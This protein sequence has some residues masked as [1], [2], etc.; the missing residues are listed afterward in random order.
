MKV[1]K[2]VIDEL[3]RQA[4]SLGYKDILSAC[5][6]KYKISWSGNSVKL[7]LKLKRSRK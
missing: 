1:S 7:V 4:M 2:L 6:D 5:K 3:Q